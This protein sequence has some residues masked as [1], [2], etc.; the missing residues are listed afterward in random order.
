[1]WQL[2][3]ENKI[4]ECASSTKLVKGCQIF[5]GTTHQKGK[6]YTKEPQNIPNGH[7]IYRMAVK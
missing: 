3:S 4:Q 5:L 6:K 1:M 2:S 7:K